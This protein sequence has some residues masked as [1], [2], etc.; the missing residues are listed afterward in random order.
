MVAIVIVEE[1][2]TSVPDAQKIC[3]CHHFCAFSLM[4]QHFMFSLEQE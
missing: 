1:V 4:L 3:L 2:P